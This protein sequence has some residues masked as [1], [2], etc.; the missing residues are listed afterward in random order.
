MKNVFFLLLIGLFSIMSCSSND[1]DNQGNGNWLISSDEVFDGGPGKDGI[2]SIDNPK[3]ES[4]SQTTL[5]NPDDLVI[6]VVYNG[7]AKAY[8]H[9]ILDR[10][11]IVNDQVNDRYVALT[12]CPLTGTAIAWNR[13]LDSGVTTFGVSGKLYN[14]NLMPYDRASDSYWSQIRLDCV[15]GPLLN[16]RIETF[17]IIETTWETWKA[18]YPNSMIMTEETGF[19]RN[20]NEFPYGIIKQIIII[21]FSPSTM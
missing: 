15:N 2:P 8:A 7:V 21:F 6:G 1:T 5:L 12:Y 18:M 19:N 11:E 9:R 3:F 13:M 14:T 10:H 20:Y 16:T 17:P 4:V